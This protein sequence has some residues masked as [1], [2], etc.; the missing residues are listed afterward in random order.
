MSCGE[1][2]T[3]VSFVLEYNIGAFGK[4]FYQEGV[5]LP[6]GSPAAPIMLSLIL[7][8]LEY[9]WAQKHK[10]KKQFAK[11]ENLKFIVRFYDDLLS[12]EERT[13][14]IHEIYCRGFETKLGEKFN[15]LGIKFESGIKGE[16]SVVFLDYKIGDGFYSLHTKSDRS[17]FVN[18]NTS[19]ESSTKN[20]IIISQLYR[21]MRRSSNRFLFVSAAYKILTFFAE[22][23]YPKKALIRGV[24]SFFKKHL[25][26]KERK[27]ILTYLRC[28]KFEEA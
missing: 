26:F 7:S 25:M 9:R 4:S 18:F 5:G 21:C 8:S 28:L 16:K 17:S 6:Q 11:L 1:V 13:P 12:T 23:Q 3:L 24:R 10:K 22:S 20:G 14:I 15:D 27:K 2:K 19:L